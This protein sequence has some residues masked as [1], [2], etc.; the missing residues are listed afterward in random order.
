M[1]S[2]IVGRTVIDDHEFRARRTGPNRRNCLTKGLS[3]IEAGHDDRDPAGKRVCFDFP[4]SRH[5]D[6]MPLLAVDAPVPGAGAAGASGVRA[7]K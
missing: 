4:T 2:V 5:V 6:T 3:V 7:T 1:E